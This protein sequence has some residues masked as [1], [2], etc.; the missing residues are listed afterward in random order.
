MGDQNERIKWV[1][2]IADEI[3]GYAYDVDPESDDAAGRRAAAEVLT[4]ETLAAGMR[5]AMAIA[6][7]W[8][9]RALEAG[10][11]LSAP[12][13]EVHRRRALMAR[14]IGET[15]RKLCSALVAGDEITDELR[16]ILAQHGASPAKLT[17]PPPAAPADGYP[18]PMDEDDDDDEPAAPVAGSL[19]DYDHGAHVVEV[20]AELGL[21]PDDLIAQ[22]GKP[23]GFTLVGATIL[24]R[25]ELVL[26]HGKVSKSRVVFRATAV[27]VKPRE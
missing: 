21:I 7:W 9:A 4:R 11:G 27:A 26:E 18:P 10:N 19:A 20:H 6:Q 23:A 15:C 2:D 22:S 5:W 3:E 25:A 17:A 1:G 24:E 8:Q 12:D 16:A 13:Q 14:D